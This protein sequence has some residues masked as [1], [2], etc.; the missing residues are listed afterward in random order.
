M[1]PGRSAESGILAVIVDDKGPLRKAGHMSYPPPG[2]PAY[3]PTPMAPSEETTWCALAHASALVL[4]IIGPLLIMV[5]LGAR[6]PRV[7]A[8]STEA[9]NFQITY[10]LAVLASVPL[11]FVVVGFVTFVVAMVAYY[12]LAILATVTA[13]RGIDYR[14][15]A[16]LRF[17]H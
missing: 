7:R 17:V 10:A 1:D 2:P 12:V 14:Y 16:I 8:A 11:F 15:P 6:S 4:A 13:A 9:L 3:G 5:T